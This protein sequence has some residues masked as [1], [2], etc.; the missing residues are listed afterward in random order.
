MTMTETVRPA[1]AADM[2][3]IT[4]TA[5]FD[6]PREVVW[7][8]LTDRE[9]LGRWYHPARENLAEGQDYTLTRT[10]DD[11]AQ[12]A[13]IWGK[14]LEM[15][16]PSLLRV[17]FVIEPMGS[18]ETEV[19]YILEEA[20]GGT[21]L[22]LIHEGVGAAMAGEALG[23]LGHLDPGWDEHIGKLRAAVKAG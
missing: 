11:G 8:F 6:A 1:A 10:G 16:A 17:T 2:D 19:T 22:T 5:F 13:L 12:V 14:V 4:K 21:R 18:G 9:K 23:L 3:T 20:L 15:R 7:S